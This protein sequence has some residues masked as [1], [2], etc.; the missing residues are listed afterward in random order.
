M[1]EKYF[2]TKDRL[3]QEKRELGVL[4]KERAE[5]EDR[6]GLLTEIQLLR[7]YQR[8][9]E[10]LETEVKRN[11]EMKR[12]LGWWWEGFKRSGENI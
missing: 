7:D 10:D 5:H 2:K 11:A 12:R 3:E 1:E 9:E 8:T 6:A 4:K